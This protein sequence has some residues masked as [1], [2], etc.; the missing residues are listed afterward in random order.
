[1]GG[2]PGDRLRVEDV[3]VMAPYRAQVLRL[4]LLLRGRGM[5]AVRQGVSLLVVYRSTRI[6]LHGLTQR[7]L[8]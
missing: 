1:V 5:G 4:R 3:G 8:S 2:R 6:L 7:S